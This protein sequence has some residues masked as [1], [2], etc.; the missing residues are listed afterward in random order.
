MKIS[1]AM[2][3][4]ILKICN[5]RNISVNKLATMCCLTQSTI[6]NIVECNSN[7]SKLLT[8]VRICDGIGISL[9]EFFDDEIFN[10]ID[11]ED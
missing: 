3:K 10:N 2:S 7:N 5:E 8:V 9:K 4:K 1:E 11:R 6:Q